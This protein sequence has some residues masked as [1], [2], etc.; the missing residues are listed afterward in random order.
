MSELNAWSNGYEVVAATSEAHARE[1]LV[2]WM[3]SEN[4]IATDDDEI[5]GDGWRPLSLERIVGN[6]CG[7]PP[8]LLASILAESP[9]PRHLWSV[10]Q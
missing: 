3:K 5:D 10:D 6:D 9:E 1:V 7:D 2:A 4:I 8:Q